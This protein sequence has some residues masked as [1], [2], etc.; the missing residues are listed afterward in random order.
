M[1]C[2]HIQQTDYGE[3]SEK[4][5]AITSERHIPLSCS[6]ELTFRCNLRC[7]HCYASHG[8]TG[9]PDLQELSTIEIKSL[10][11]EFADHGCLWILLT[12]GEPLM[13]RDFSDIYLHVKRKGMIP[14]L[15]TNGTTITER[16]A[17]MLAEYKP[18][19]IEITLYGYTQDT[20][21]RVTGV[22]GS[23]AR[24]MRGIE[25][26]LERDLPL[27]LKTMLINL[28]KH[29][30]QQMQEFADTLNLDFRFDPIV[31]PGIVE[32]DRPLSYRLDP[33]E[34]LQFEKDDPERVVEW[35][36]Q[37]PVLLDM[38][39]NSRLIYNC[40]AGR[41]TFH[42]DPYGKMSICL[43]SRSERYDL[44]AGS[45]SEGWNEFIPEFRAR[46]S[47]RGYVCASCDIRNACTSCPAVAELEC[48]DPEAVVGYLCQ[49]SKMRAE[50]FGCSLFSRSSFIVEK[51]QNYTNYGTMAVNQG[52]DYGG[53][54]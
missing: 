10:L 39:K 44:R 23:H 27:G 36:K 21:E 52:E 17:D 9:T 8:H 42:I 47:S 24:C 15:F 29:E 32:H 54:N 25:L 38:P 20:Y 26:L 33:E 43:M 1:D 3:F 13:R 12:G 50:E 31:S 30:L 11:D 5:H 4:L 7:V 45:F 46:E 51:E 41:D 35:R 16:S 14:T 19:N 49:I 18:L 34:V 53:E 40:T 37:M 6:F 22:P 2:L 48:G 28:N